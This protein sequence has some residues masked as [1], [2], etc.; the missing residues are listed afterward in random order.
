ML[1]LGKLT[2]CSLLESS[3][4][5][6]FADTEIS[7]IRDERSCDLQAGRSYVWTQHSPSA[8]E[9]AQTDTFSL[10]PEADTRTEHRWYLWLG[11]G[12]E[13]RSC[14][15]RMLLVKRPAPEGRLT[16]ATIL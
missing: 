15:S 1:S 16:L 7:I 6:I 8:A 9:E 10:S 5:Q 13:M 12:L 2:Y 14:F 11:R 3:Q 4:I